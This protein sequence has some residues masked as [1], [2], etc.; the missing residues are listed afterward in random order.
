MKY[1]ALILL[2]FFGVLNAHAQVDRTLVVWDSLVVMPAGWPEENPYIIMYSMTCMSKPALDHTGQPHKHGNVVQVIMDGG[3]NVQDPP[4]LDGTPGGDDSLAF[5]N[6]NTFRVLGI[7]GLNDYSGRTGT[8]FS[9]KFFIPFL[10]NRL[11]YLRLWEGPDPKTAP[12]YN[13]TVEYSTEDDRGGAM[14]RFK[15]GVPHDVDFTFGP[16]KARPQ[17]AQPDKSKKS[18]KK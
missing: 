8:F 3:N 1:L 9:Q 7:D 17:P 5:G 13:E 2:V 12:Y 6:F 18:G 4:N 11:Y 14:L 15:S 16:S 10:A